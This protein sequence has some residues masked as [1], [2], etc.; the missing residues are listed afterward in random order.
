MAATGSAVKPGKATIVYAIPMPDDSPMAGA[1]TAEIALNGRV[2]NSGLHG[3]AGGNRTHDL[4][5]KSPLLCQLS[6]SPTPQDRGNEA[7]RHF[8]KDGPGES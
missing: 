8:N 2:M 5:V 3:G 6:Y 4:R 1:D 7:T